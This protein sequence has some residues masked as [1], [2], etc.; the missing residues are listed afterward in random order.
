MERKIPFFGKEIKIYQAWFSGELGSTVWDSALV[1]IKYLENVEEFPLNYFRGKRVV[2]LGAGTGAVGIAI[3]ML[4]AEAIIT[5]K[6][7]LVGLIQRNIEDNFVSHY[8]KAAELVWGQDVSQFNP[9]VD[10]IVASDIVSKTYSADFQNLV[11]TF[12][13][14]S[15]LNTRILLAYEKR[16]PGDV[17]FFRMLSKYF[18]YTKVKEESTL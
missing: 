10:V 18:K 13:E 12:Y 8:C 6:K 9:P 7:E 1:L 5:D 14:L 15:D 16:D 3:G 4:G 2:E 17:E 11:K